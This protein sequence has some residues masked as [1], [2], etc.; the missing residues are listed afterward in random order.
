MDK[1]DWE[2]Q[3]NIIKKVERLRYIVWDGMLAVHVAEKRKLYVA[4]YQS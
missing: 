2:W 1:E 4:E 3:G